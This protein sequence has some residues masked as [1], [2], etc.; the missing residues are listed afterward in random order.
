MEIVFLFYPK[1]T[2][3]DLVGPYEVLHRLP[4]ATVKHVAPEAGPVLSGTGITMIAEHSIHDVQSADVL[5]VPGACNATNLH[6]FPDILAWIQQIH[7]T[8]TWTTSV[9]TGSL[10]LGAAGLLKGIQA[11]THWAVMER[12]STWGAIP[13]EQRV[14]EDGK[15]MTAAG[16]SA[17]I[18]M[19]LTLAAKIAGKEVAQSL[20]LGLEYD[21]SPPFHCG[22]PKKADPELVA[23]LKTN[24]LDRFEK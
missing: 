12:L 20:Q 22:S 23:E 9:C 21:P 1:M 17:G 13:T 19:A 10:V 3:L 8:T 16:V 11:T 4:G 24:L 15:M 7:S 2:A 6:Q 14:V 18:D 5:C